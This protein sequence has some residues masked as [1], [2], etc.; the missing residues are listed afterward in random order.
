MTTAA[1]I[2]VKVEPDA[3]EYIEQ[4]GMRAEFERMLEHTRSIVPGL[5]AI[6]VEYDHDPSNTI[7]PGIII[8]SHRDEPP[9]PDGVDND[10]GRWKVT[11]F[12]TEVCLQ[13]VMLSAYGGGG[14]GR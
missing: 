6:T 14:N 1:T 12:P 9:G 4:L 7:G 2:P 10:W 11:T 8:W 13:F 3:A 5:R